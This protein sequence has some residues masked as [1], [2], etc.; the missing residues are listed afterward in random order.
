MVVTVHSKPGCP[1]CDVAVA[2]LSDLGVPFQ[3][4]MY[5]PDSSDYERRRDDLF[6]LYSHRS[7][8]HILVGDTFLGGLRELKAAIASTRLD[9]LLAESGVYID[10]F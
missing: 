8:P 6:S 5:M 2:L 9:K 1:H 4:V 3:K 7:F 10:R